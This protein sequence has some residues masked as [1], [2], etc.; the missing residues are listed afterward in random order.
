MHGR[1]VAIG[2]CR[3]LCWNLIARS[4]VG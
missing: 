2:C 1:P 3:G 4:P